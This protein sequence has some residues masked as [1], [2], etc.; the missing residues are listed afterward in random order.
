MSGRRAEAGFSLIEVAIALAIISIALVPTAQMWIGI[1]QANRAIGQKAQ[2]LVVAQQVLER[3]VRSKA[4]D[5]QPLGSFPG[6]DA[7]SGLDY[8]LERSA[9]GT[10]MKRAEVRVFQAGEPAPLIRMVT[11][12]AKE[13]M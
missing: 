2:A 3:E 12:T 6:V 1:S 4:Y 10:R 9:S 7:T 5:D 13:T 11:M 8:V